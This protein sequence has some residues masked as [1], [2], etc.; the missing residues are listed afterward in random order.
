MVPGAGGEGDVVCNGDSFS[1]LTV[2]RAW[3]SPQKGRILGSPV[4][5]P[6]TGFIGSSSKPG[7]EERTVQGGASPPWSPRVDL[8]AR[9]PAQSL[10]TA[11][12]VKVSVTH[13]GVSL[14]LMEILL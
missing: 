1:V 3:C 4:V 5:L 10:P 8:A 12:S 11:F 14:L 6:G 9:A 7:K 13:S 2:D